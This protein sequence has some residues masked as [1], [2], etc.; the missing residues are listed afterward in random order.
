[1][2]RT[3]MAELF[4]SAIRIDTNLEGRLLRRLG[5]LAQTRQR[6]IPRLLDGGLDDHMRPFVVTEPIFTPTL[7]SLLRDSQYLAGYRVANCVAEIARTLQAAH[8]L[9]LVHGRVCPGNIHL[10]ASR[11]QAWVMGW[12]DGAMPSIRTHELS[13]R[14]GSASSYLAPEVF[15]DEIIGPAADVYGT[16][17]VLHELLTG[18]PP[19]IPLRARHPSISKKLQ[20]VIERAL[21]PDARRRWPSADS[22]ASAIE[23]A[24]P[25]AATSLPTELH[26]IERPARHSRRSVSGALAS[27]LALATLLTFVVIAF[28]IMRFFGDTPLIAKG[29]AMSVPS[30]Q[31]KTVAEAQQIASQSDTQLLVVG[32]RESDRYPA[33]QIMHQTPVPGWH[34]YDRQPVRVTVSTGVIVPDVLGKSITEAAK[35]AN[36]LG[37]KVAR[38]EPAPGKGAEATTILMQSPKPGELV[39]DAG[40]LA[41]VIA[42]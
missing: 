2:G 27:M 41:L 14:P 36:E 20:P 11:E 15:R 10:D 35:Q 3:V 29:V 34:L 39:R 17:V 26:P 6:G 18:R 38:V 40:E 8:D 24:T 13:A 23:D 30:L 22:L 12:V 21:E 7:R 42:E 37:W 33:G 28:G 31:G 9:G 1:M 5:R 19:E 4:S 32:E 25:A 16:G